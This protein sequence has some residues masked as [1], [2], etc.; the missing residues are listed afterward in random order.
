MDILLFTASTRSAFL[1]KKFR[2]VKI[3]LINAPMLHKN[4]GKR[5]GLQKEADL[6]WFI[7]HE[8]FDHWF[9]N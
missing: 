9:R 6:L 3:S 7:S 2:L 5:A 1:M 8:N 4:W